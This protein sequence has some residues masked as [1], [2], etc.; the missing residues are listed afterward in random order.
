MAPPNFK[1]YRFYNAQMDEHDSLLNNN[2]FIY[3]RVYNIF[4]NTHASRLDF[5]WFQAPFGPMWGSLSFHVRVKLGSC[6]G[7]GAL[8]TD[9]KALLILRTTWRSEL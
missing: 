6:R 7:L 3:Q 2:M 9:F 8:L 1:C 4:E 5:R